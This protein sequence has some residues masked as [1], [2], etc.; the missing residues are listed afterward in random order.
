MQ[1]AT[2]VYE[3]EMGWWLKFK[4]IYEKNEAGKFKLKVGPTR[5]RGSK[6]VKVRI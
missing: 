4:V 5:V 6:L 1:F 3:K 2:D